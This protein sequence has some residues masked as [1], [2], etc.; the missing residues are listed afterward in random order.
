MGSSISLLEMSEKPE[1][2]SFLKKQ[3]EYCQ[4]LNLSDAETNDH[5]MNE[6]YNRLKQTHPEYKSPKHTSHPIPRK[7]VIGTEKMADPTQITKSAPIVVHGLKSPPHKPQRNLTMFDMPP[8]KLG[9]R[10]VN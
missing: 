8:T 3:Y 5:M 4:S 9:D 1:M 10:C 7:S 6:F 2:A